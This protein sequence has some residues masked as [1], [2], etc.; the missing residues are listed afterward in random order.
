MAFEAWLA[1]LVSPMGRNGG[2]YR[3]TTRR[4]VAA[5]LLCALGIAGVMAAGTIH[6]WYL[7]PGYAPR[8]P[9]VWLGAA[10]FVFALWMFYVS[11]F[12]A[13]FGGLPWL[14]LQALA[15]RRDRSLVGVEQPDGAVTGRRWWL[16]PLAGFVV[17][18][19]VAFA[20]TTL[21]GRPDP[22]LRN[23]TWLDGKAVIID[24]RL[25]PYGMSVYGPVAAV[26]NGLI[27]GGVGAGFGLLLWRLAYRRSSRT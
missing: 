22:T 11:A 2:V 24:G 16:A 14:V 10:L 8:N 13:V 9:L 1:G 15:Q 19:C 21:A 18:F 17:M 7:V 20:V 12:F 5:L 27:F 26:R 23:S 4:A 25:T 3:T 6:D